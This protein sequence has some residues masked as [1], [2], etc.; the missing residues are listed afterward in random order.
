[1]YTDINSKPSHNLHFVDEDIND[2]LHMLYD[3]SEERLVRLLADKYNL[4]YIDLRGVAGEPD[5]LKLI[6]ENM[7]REALVAP[8]R[9]TGKTIHIAVRDPENSKMRNLIE[10]INNS[11]GEPIIYIASNASLSH[12]WGRYADIAKSSV[13]D[14][15]SINLTKA[16]SDELFSDV[17]SIADFQKKM[18]ETIQNERT[19]KISKIIELMIDGAI[20]FGASDIHTEPQSDGVRIRYRLDGLLSD[21]FYTDEETYKLIQ[22][23]LKLLSGLKISM[24]GK[25]Q[26]GRFTI[27]REVGDIEVR[28]SVIPGSYG[29]NFVM[30]LLDPA[31]ASVDLDTLGINIYVKEAIEKAMK[32][33]NGMILT[34]GPTGSGK[35]T[36]LYSILE[37]IYNPNIKIITIED[38]VEYHVKGISQTNVNKEYGFVDGL[39]AA[40]RQDPDV[41]MIGEIRDNETALVAINAAQTG[42]LVLS[43]LHTNNAFG[44]IP[45]LLDLGANPKTLG[46]AIS[47]AV[48]QRLCRKLCP[49]C[50]VASMSSEQETKSI[51]NILGEMNLKNKPF[52]IK[53]SISYTLFRAA[54]CDKCNEGY[55][56][57]IGIYEAFIMTP[58]INTIINNNPSEYEIKE[59]TSSQGLTTLAEDSILKLLNGETSYDELLRVVEL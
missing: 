46:S 56:G 23:R 44:V 26:D 25:A 49:H 54:G 37:K 36:T 5:A 32:K 42:H 31:N 38:P 8:F 50:K 17:K 51:T 4:P 33:P 45:R 18:E 48:A 59:A 9:I 30:R 57:R 24:H 28:V 35:S 52:A 41:I 21:V 27:E 1:M 14:Q 12:V 58:D 7:A 20:Y 3:D 11:L 40:L 55:K 53:P 16:H 29:E 43:T 15:G 47:L 13:V 2:N 39:R 34:T 19:G 10:H 22:S 6:P